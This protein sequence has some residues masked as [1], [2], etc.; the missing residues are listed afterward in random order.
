VSFV[1]FFF[2]TQCIELHREA[3]GILTSDISTCL[4]QQPSPKHQIAYIYAFN[5]GARV[6]Y[7]TW[8]GIFP[9]GLVKLCKITRI[10]KVVRR[11]I[12]KK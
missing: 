1:A 11:F 12:I 4:F 9:I 2:G 10:I 8:V 6:H 7:D 5:L 3:A